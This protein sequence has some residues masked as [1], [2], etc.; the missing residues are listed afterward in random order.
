M[1]AGGRNSYFRA[2][3]KYFIGAFSIPIGHDGSRRLGWPCVADFVRIGPRLEL[4]RSRLQ[5]DIYRSRFNETLTVGSLSAPIPTRFPTMGSTVEETSS[6]VG[7]ILPRVS[8]CRC[9]CTTTIRRLRPFA[10]RRPSKCIRHRFPAR[11]SRWGSQQ[12][13]GGLVTASIRD[14]NDPSF[15]FP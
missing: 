2:Y 1:A 6:G 7:I 8:Q 10:F 11:I 3:T 12:F 13:Y 5:G 4:T 9:R 14:K 15:T